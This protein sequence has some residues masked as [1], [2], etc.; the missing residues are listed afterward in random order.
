MIMILHETP[1]VNID[2]SF[3]NVGVYETSYFAGS[4]HRGGEFSVIELEEVVYKSDTI[5]VVFKNIPS[6]HTPIECMIN[7]H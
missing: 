2:E 1:A 4:A 3:S 5:L 6:I 7:F